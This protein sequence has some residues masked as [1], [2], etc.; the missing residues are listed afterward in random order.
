MIQWKYEVQEK[1]RNSLDLRHAFIL[2]LFKNFPK[3]QFWLILG[4]TH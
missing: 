4:D 1:W 2:S 3:P